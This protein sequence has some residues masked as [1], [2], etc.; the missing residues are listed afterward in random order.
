M[1]RPLRLEF[2]N[3]LYHITS[4]GNERKDIFTDSADYYKLLSYLEHVA[5]RY[6]PIVYC[7]CVMENHYH[8]LLETPQPNL[9]RLMRDLNGAYTIYFNRRHKRSGH[10]FQ[11]RYKA[12]LVDKESYLLELSRYIHLNPVRAKIAKFPEEHKYSSADYYFSGRQPPFWLNTEFIISQFGNNKKD[13]REDYRKFVYR[14]LA[15]HKDPL[16]DAY[17][18]AI[19]G[20]AGFVNKIKS[21]FLSKRDIP[22]DISRSK[23]LRS[24]KDLSEIAELVLKH[25]NTDLETLRRRGGKA[26]RAKK[27]FVYFSRKYTDSGLQQIRNFLNNSVSAAAISKMFSRTE[28]ELE[29]QE[30]LRQDVRSLD[31][32]LFHSDL[33]K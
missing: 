3:A 15:D 12:I 11:G 31:K 5:L 27:L 25:Y 23:A 9:S 33:E 14:G 26:N 29:K 10:L 21:D 24:A 22:E 17:A 18:N 30:G 20:S 28:A 1:A 19:L 7:Y 16:K 13:A 6:K 2:E 32:L 4:R 8:L